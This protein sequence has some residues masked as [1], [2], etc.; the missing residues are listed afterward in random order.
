MEQGRERSAYKH[1]LRS[2]GSQADAFRLGSVYVEQILKRAKPA[3]LQVRQSMRF[4]LVINL[5]TVKALSLDV[6]ANL[7][8]IRSPG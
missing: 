5:K 4:D 8:R 7:K 1:Q 2:A 6:P 3:G